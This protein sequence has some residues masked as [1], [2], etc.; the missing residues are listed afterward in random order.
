[1]DVTEWAKTSQALCLHVN[2]HLKN[3]RSQSCG[4]RVMASTGSKRQTDDVSSLYSCVLASSCIPAEQKKKIYGSRNDRFWGC[5]MR[6][7]T[8]LILS[9]K[10]ERANQLIRL[11]QNH[12]IISPYNGHDV[13]SLYTVRIIPQLRPHLHF[14]WQNIWEKHKTL[15]ARM[16]L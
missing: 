11:V 4:I 16:S 12:S 5:Y 10:R 7:C 3:A 2:R 8:W 1:M 6:S 9:Y 13:E 15:V 14:T